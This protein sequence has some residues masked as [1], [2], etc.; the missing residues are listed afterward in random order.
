[1]PVLGPPVSWVS[2]Y[3]GLHPNVP[4]DICFQLAQSLQLLHGH[5]ICHGDFR[6]ANILFQL[7]DDQTSTNGQRKT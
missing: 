3:Y 1:M 2:E 6:P 5:G 7:A 4:K